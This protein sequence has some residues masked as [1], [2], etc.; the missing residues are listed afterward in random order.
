MKNKGLY[1]KILIFFVVVFLGLA[2]LLKL[3]LLSKENLDKVIYILEVYLSKNKQA[4]PILFIAVFVMRTFFVIFPY[5]IMVVI[6]GKIFGPFLGI[7]LSIISVFISSTAAFYLSRHFGFKFIEKRLKGRLYS[8]ENKIEKNGL[9]L[10]F[11]MR[12]S[13][14]FPFDIISFT[15]GVTKIKYRKFILGTILGVIPETVSLNFLGSNIGNPF[16]KEFFVSIILVIIFVLVIPIAI[17]KSK[18]IM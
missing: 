8:I 4:A 18:Q 10:I 12:L 15:A 5:T 11:L 3:N 14:L 6:G 13:M 1:I 2:I 17:K 7:I 9:K 16:S